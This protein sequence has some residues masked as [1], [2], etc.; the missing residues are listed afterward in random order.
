LLILAN[1]G[2]KQQRLPEG[3]APVNPGECSIAGRRY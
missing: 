3:S 1:R 2:G